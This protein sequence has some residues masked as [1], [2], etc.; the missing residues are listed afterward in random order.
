MDGMTG[1]TLAA[2]IVLVAALVGC[3][4]GGVAAYRGRWEPLR[5]AM[6]RD[7]EGHRMAGT[8]W[9]GLLGLPMA[10]LVLADPAGDGS[11]TAVHGLAVAAMGMLLV[12]VMALAGNR[13]AALT[14]LFTPRWLLVERARRCGP[15]RP[16][17]RADDP[18]PCR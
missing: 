12:P 14:R 10:V 1:T 13:P 18:Q 15:L 7:P 17:G 8:L 4:A 9:L 5:R 2:A 6:V 11:F 3:T 16:D